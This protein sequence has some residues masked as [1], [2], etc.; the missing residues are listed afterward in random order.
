MEVVQVA[1]HIEKIIIEIGKCRREIEA[2]G[3]ARAKAISN[4]DM[5]LGIAIVT[6]KEE[7][8]FPA[9]LIEKIAK[10]ICSADREE[11]EISE[12]GYKACICNLEALQAQLNG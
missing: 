11:L 6:L 12:S 10:K 1:Q 8:K 5:R 3:I 2:K 4:Y 9:T 7:G